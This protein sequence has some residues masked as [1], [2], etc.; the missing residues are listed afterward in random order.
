MGT[1]RSSISVY[2]S[3]RARIK[4]SREI[5]SS[6]LIL[7]VESP[8]R[9]IQQKTFLRYVVGNR[10]SNLLYAGMIFT[11]RRI[12]RAS[13]KTPRFYSSYRRVAIIFACNGED[14]EGR[15]CRVISGSK[16]S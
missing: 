5:F 6:G 9:Q 13:Q 2:T 8:S 15:V 16:Y 10:E 14:W 3:C 12:P 1:F 4:N 11:V 7:S